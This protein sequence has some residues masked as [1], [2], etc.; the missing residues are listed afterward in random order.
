MHIHVGWIASGAA[1]RKTCRD[2]PTFSWVD[3]EEIPLRVP[4]RANAAGQVL[5]LTVRPLSGR[6][7]ARGSRVT[8]AHCAATRVALDARGARP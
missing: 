1:H 7:E 3:P 4:G 5:D 6:I 8:E 2:L